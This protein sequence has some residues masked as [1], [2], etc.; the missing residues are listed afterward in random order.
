MLDYEIVQG[1][2]ADLR[3]EADVERQ[4]AETPAGNGLARWVG[5]RLLG[6]KDAQSGEGLE[7]AS[8]TMINAALPPQS[9]ERGE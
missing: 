8:N 2:L 4:V 5:E 1:R 9:C 6:N 3:R 7:R